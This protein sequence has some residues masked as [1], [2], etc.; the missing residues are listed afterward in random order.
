MDAYSARISTTLS[1]RG[2]RLS[3]EDLLQIWKYKIYGAKEG[4][5]FNSLEIIF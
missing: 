3:N 2:R 1:S 5:I 4:S